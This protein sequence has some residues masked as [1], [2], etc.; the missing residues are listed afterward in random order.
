[1]KCCFE[2]INFYF[3]YAELKQL[4]E[5]DDKFLVAW[6]IIERVYAEK[7]DKSKNAMVGHFFRVSDRLEVEDDKI[8]G[9]LHDIV[10]DNLL[11]FNDL[12]YLGIPSHIIEA[13]KLLAHDKVV[14]PNY[15]DYITNILESDN[16]MAIR[17]KYADMLDNTCEIRLSKLDSQI[18]KNLENK[19]RS[20]LPRLIDKIE[21]L[22]RN[23]NIKLERKLV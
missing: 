6:I 19:Y 4:Q 16:E 1:M 8:C 12:L 17:V 5:I 21:E 9:L 10:E 2:K 3:N 13:L 23:N 7:L 20:Q 18:R 11:T 15:I 14:C 22:D